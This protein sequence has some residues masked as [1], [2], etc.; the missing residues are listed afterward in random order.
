M[1]MTGIAKKYG[2]ALLGDNG[3]T[4]ML[5]KLKDLAVKENQMATA[6]TLASVKGIGAPSPVFDP[7]SIYRFPI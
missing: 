5:Q 4:E 1:D 3:T 7:S 2:R 6:E